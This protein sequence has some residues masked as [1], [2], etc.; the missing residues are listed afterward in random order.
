MV[1]CAISDCRRLSPDPERARSLL[2]GLARDW[3]TAGVELIQLRE[4]HLAAGEL[5][6][7]A[8][9]LLQV[10]RASGSG[11]TRLLINGRADVAIAA[12]A[13]G[14]HLTGH[15]EELAPAQVRELFAHAGLP[16]PT[17]SVSCHSMDDVRR[18]SEQSADY[19]LFGPVFEKWSG[20]D[21]LGG[22]SGIDRLREA[23]AAA[24]STPV[25][26]LGGVTRENAAT[27]LE[28]G[29]TGIA[30]IRLFAE[31]AS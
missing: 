5:L 16:A 6:T 12:G 18:A 15:H 25:L 4:K 31:T 29:A 20:A 26:A 22:G 19:I 27:C 13:E 17:I 11:S 24:G 23:C 28:A 9:E 1:R 14:V 7:L 21:R 10:V 8:Q 2:L 3:A 30:A